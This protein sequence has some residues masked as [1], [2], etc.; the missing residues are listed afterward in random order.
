MACG[1][2][3]WLAIAVCALV[4][5]R[6]LRAARARPLPAAWPDV[7]VICPLCGASDA[8]ADNLKALLGVAYDGMLDV[9]FV[10][11]DAD[12]PCWPVL[13]AVEGE[14]PRRGRR[15]VAGTAARWLPKTW[16]LA[17]GIAAAR[18][19][20]LVFVDAD[21]RLD[22]AVLRD[23]VAGV[24]R[25][26]A[27]AAYAHPVVAE[28][29]GAGGWLEA[30]VVNYTTLA[31]Q[32][33]LSRLGLDHLAGTLWAI[34]RPVLDAAGGFE[35]VRES[36]A[37]DISL[38]GRLRA[39]GAQLVLV[40]RP[41]VTVQ[42]HMTIAD[43]ARHQLRWLRTWR[44]MAGA[45]WPLAL[46]FSSLVPACAGALLGGPWIAVAPLVVAEMGLMAWIESELN[47]RARPG[48]LAL[49]APLAL[50]AEQVLALVALCGRSVR[51]GRYRFVLD[52]RGRILRSAT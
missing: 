5:R 8:L 20:D 16:S 39:A 45:T 13:D 2:L 28:P 32:P 3:L 9:V 27:A 29:R 46:L 30:A 33:I 44:R 36:I 6:L 51:W 41:V 18:F 26:D 31:V 24:R 1:Y 35:G 38:G 42:G 37:D 48:G 12:D 15:I 17:R 21:V 11:A 25:F 10:A 34:R 52:S 47:G 49:V 43:F 19:E 50:A 23:V 4:S 40:G 22:A 14:S 7:S